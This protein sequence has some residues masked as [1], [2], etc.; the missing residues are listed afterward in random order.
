[1][2]YISYEFQCALCNTQ[3]NL[4]VCVCICLYLPYSNYTVLVSV[5]AY[6][7]R[8][9]YLNKLEGKFDCRTCVYT[10]IR[11][12]GVYFFR[13]REKNTEKHIS[14]KH[15]HKNL[16]NLIIFSRCFRR[17]YGFFPCYFYWYFFFSLENFSQPLKNILT[18]I[19]NKRTSEFCF[20]EQRIS[21]ITI[22]N[23]LFSAELFFS[24]NL[25]NSISIGFIYNA[26]VCSH[27]RWM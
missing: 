8:M 1:M 19:S 24:I 22:K 14:P 2:I 3:W 11:Q 4:L 27:F 6:R 17:N 5:C 13:K 12:S 18:I 7:N 15:W 10:L 26:F 20:F 23:Y 16:K 25:S 9:E 21:Q